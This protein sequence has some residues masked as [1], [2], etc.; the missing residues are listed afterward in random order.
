MARN[1]AKLGKCAVISLMT[2]DISRINALGCVYATLDRFES[3]IDFG[4]NAS[5]IVGG[6]EK[7]DKP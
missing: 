2:I 4:D 5:G 6:E 1:S 7:K 3:I